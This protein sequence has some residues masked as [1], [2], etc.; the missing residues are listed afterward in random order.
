M[1]MHIITLGC[2]KNIVDSEY[3]IGVLSQSGQTFIDNPSDSDVIIINTC[4]FILE[5]REEAIQT[6]LEAVQIKQADNHKQIYVVG[7]LPQKYKNELECSIPEVDGFFDQ[8]DFTEIAM[9]IANKMKHHCDG[10]RARKLITPGH[11]AYLKIA[12]GCNNSCTYCTIPLIKGNYHSKDMEPLEQEI[13]ALVDNGVRELIVIAQDTTFYGRDKKRNV[14]LI[15]L[16]ERI[17]SYKELRWV[18]LLYTHPAH[19]DDQLIACIR[20]EKKMCR[21]IDLPLQHIS[22]HILEKMGRKISGDQIRNLIEK[23]RREIPDIAI[24]TSLIVGFPGET[25]E[26]FQELLQFVKDIRFERLGVFKY[27]REEETRAASLPRQVKEGE[28]EDRLQEIM[29]IQSMISLENNERLV[30]KTIEA[31]I[32]NFDTEENCYIARSQWDSPDIDNRIL[33]HSSAT[34]GSFVPVVIEQAFEY[35]LVGKIAW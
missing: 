27:S 5:A 32:D 11:Y 28:K 29:E 35:D 13:S 4:A 16:L 21:Y 22:D 17:C 2:P 6:I 30:N 8:L 33:I 15:N 1:K 31:V 9:Q 20:D 10:T 3:L 18:R 14:N 23:L 25:E 19:I 7:C 26:D 24:R 12:E 34:I